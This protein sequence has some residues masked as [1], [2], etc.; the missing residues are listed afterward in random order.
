M[1]NIEFTPEEIE[2]LNYERYHHPQPKVQQRM[3]A[4]YLKSK[5]LSHQNIMIVSN[6]SSRTTLSTW[7]KL[8]QTG[9][10]EALSNLCYQGQKSELDGH[11]VSIKSYFEQNPPHSINEAVDAIEKLTGIQRSPSQVREFLKKTGFKCLKVGTAPGKEL[12]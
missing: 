8:Y 3:Q 5:G 12:K 7:F 9:N 4:L 1:I 6:I 10:I 2:V 11:I